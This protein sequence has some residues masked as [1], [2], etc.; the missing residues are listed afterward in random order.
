MANCESRT[1]F[2]CSGTIVSGSIVFCG[3]GTD[4]WFLIA[5]VAAAA[6]RVAANLVALDPTVTDEIKN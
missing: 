3:E 4:G 2:G 6:S 5:I 1:I